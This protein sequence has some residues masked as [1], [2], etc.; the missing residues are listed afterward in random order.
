M[1]IPDRYVAYA[2]AFREARATDDWS[3]VES[4]FTEDAVYDVLFDPPLGGHFEGRSAILAYFK[5]SVDH[6][7]RRF[8]SREGAFIDGPRQ[9]GDT[10]WTRG[11]VVCRAAGVPDW[12]IELEESAQFE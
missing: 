2:L 1:S 4:F 12:V 9:D 10:V 5:A 6:Y 11:R 3:V 8:E 7:N